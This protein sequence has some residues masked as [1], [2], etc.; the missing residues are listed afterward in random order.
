M[1][2]SGSGYN[3]QYINP[4]IYERETTGQKQLQKE[5][6]IGRGNVVIIPQ[7]QQ[8]DV[9]F[10]HLAERN[11]LNYRSEADRPSLWPMGQM[12]GSAPLIRGN[13]LDWET[14]YLE[15][16]EA[17]PKEVKEELEY[18]LATGEAFK[19]VLQMAATLLAWQELVKIS[20]ESENALKRVENNARFSIEAFKSALEIGNEMAELS[21]KWLEI[22][23]VN[24]PAYLAANEDLANFKAILSEIKMGG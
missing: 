20:M 15:L 7:S 11:I 19:E 4:S 13:V 23:G 5:A 10:I 3:P 2:I 6:D 21:K 16:F 22:L 17:L 12:R 24:D 8:N 1:T 18:R 9:P 14:H